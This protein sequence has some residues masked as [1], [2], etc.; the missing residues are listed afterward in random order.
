V[1]YEWDGRGCGIGYGRDSDGV[2]ALIVIGNR[3]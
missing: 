1:G 3:S 2:G